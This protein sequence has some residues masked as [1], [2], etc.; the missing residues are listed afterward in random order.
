MILYTI[1]FNT[2]LTVLISFFKW[3]SLCVISISIPYLKISPTLKLKLN[4]NKYILFGLVFYKNKRRL[5]RIAVVANASHSTVRNRVRWHG[6]KKMSTV[7]S[8]QRTNQLHKYTNIL[9]WERRFETS[10]T[11][12]ADD[13]NNTDQ[14]NG[15]PSALVAHLLHDMWWCYAEMYFLSD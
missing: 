9:N 7:N 4:L 11:K 8:H 15:R 1:E 3:L 10:K 2:V 5:C 13:G 6:R 14:L 12:T